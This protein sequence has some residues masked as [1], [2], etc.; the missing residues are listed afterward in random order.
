MTSNQQSNQM[1]FLPVSRTVS[2]MGST[3]FY[4]INP[5]TS[6]NAWNNNLINTQNTNNN[7]NMTGQFQGQDHMI[8]NNY[9]PVVSAHQLN[10]FQ[11]G[12]F[13]NF[14]H[15]GLNNLN[16]SNLN[17]NTMVSA[18]Q[19]NQLQTGNFG[20]QQQGQTQKVYVRSL[21][22]QP[23]VDISET[24]SD[25]LVTACVGNLNV[26]DLNLNVTDNSVTISGT[27]W[28]GSEQIVLNRTVALTTS[29]RAEAVDA[30]FNRGILEIRMPKAEKSIRR[31]T[32]ISTDT[33]EVK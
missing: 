31:R 24:T 30:N 5:S 33:V 2:D 16:Y 10:Q 14:G 21:I 22:V 25:V 32:T 18:N 29:V 23:T 12:T 26:N 27:A 13:G 9:T 19:L 20:Y 28:T 1:K 15:S 17:Y 8:L 4:S 7:I 6:V 11:S 3:V